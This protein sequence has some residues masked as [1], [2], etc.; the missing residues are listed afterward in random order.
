[1]TRKT[2]LENSRIRKGIKTLK[3]EDEKLNSVKKS[4]H[5]K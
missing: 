3:T 2:P 1:M 4:T 5:Q